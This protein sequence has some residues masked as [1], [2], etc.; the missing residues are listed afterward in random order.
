MAPPEKKPFSFVILAIDLV[1]TATA[2][3]IFYTLVNSHVPS[4]DPAMIRLWGVLGAGCMT[5]VFWLALQML[6][7]VFRFQRD[8]R[9]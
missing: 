7:T 8:S 3:A 1:I 6:K 4:S 2:F 5:G 9:K